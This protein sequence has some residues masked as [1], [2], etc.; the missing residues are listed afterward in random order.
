V[1]Q[2]LKKYI[3]MQLYLLRKI[4]PSVFFYLTILCLT[5]IRP[6]FA[7]Q[8][9]N[10]MKIGSADAF[11][12]NFLNNKALINA[13]S[14]IIPTTESLL[15][16]SIHV[17]TT[18]GIRGK[19]QGHPTSNVF[20]DYI[21]GKIQG[22][23]IIPDEKK[24][25]N[26]FSDEKGNILVESV[27]INKVMCVD[28]YT[29]PMEPVA[30]SDFK[31]SSDTIPQLE[32]LPGATAVVYLDFDGQIV[33]GGYWNGGD[34]IDAAPAG[35]T[36]E[37]MLNAWYLTSEDYRPYKL[38]I[39]TKESVYLAAPIDKRMRCIITPTNTALPKAGGVSLIGS[40][41]AGNP[42]NSPCWVFN[43]YGTGHTTG[44]TCS[45]EIGHTM[46]LAH[47]GLNDGTQ[48]YMGNTIWAPIMGNSYTK[49]MSQWSKGEY[50]DANNTEND[51]AIIG[52]FNGFSFRIDEAGNTIEEASSLK[53]EGDKATILAA[54]NY[55]IISKSTDIDVYSFKTGA[56]NVN[57]TVNPSTDF[58]DLDILLSITDG[59]GQIVA[60]DSSTMA[61]S[62]EITTTLPAGTFYLQING[63]NNG[64]ASEGYSDYASLGEYTIQ[65]KVVPYV[66]TTLNKPEAESKMPLIHPNPATE[67]LNVKLNSPG[68]IS[69]ISIVNMLGQSIYTRQSDEQLL[70]INLSAYN[71]GIYFITISNT[72]GTTTTKFIKE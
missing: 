35:L 41:S 52:G 12:Q 49:A 69:T 30:Q 16:V 45:H 56:G 42:D 3:S 63:T 27:D 67:Q 43:L 29:T 7:Q 38:N 48:Y 17:V 70:T 23:V 19:I 39:T 50:T 40:F 64:T 71:K 13:G 44:E 55:G 4:K 24:A 34:T 62:A 33:S 57:F 61:L 15:P 8:G 21:N 32:S 31:A 46:G 2:N 65:G 11:A 54:K 22:K 36:T 68:V 72:S 9:K 5:S 18:E 14:L 47:D 1:L 60:V 37:Q 59:S 6:A 20:I 53:M 66:I 25:Y 51:I 26:Y 10:A 58:P 28:M